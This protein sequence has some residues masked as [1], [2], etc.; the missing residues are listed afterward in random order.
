MN[1][2]I[3]IP[4]QAAPDLVA[5][6]VVDRVMERVVEWTLTQLLDYSSTT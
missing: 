3:Y 2:C 5:G 6:M 1:I 4:D